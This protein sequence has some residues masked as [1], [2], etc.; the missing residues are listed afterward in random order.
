MRLNLSHKM[1]NPFTSLKYP[2]FRYFWIGMCVSTIGTWMQNVAQPWLAYSLTD[3]P[4]L[5]SLVGTLQFLPVM[6]MSLFAGAFIDR[7]PKK[8]VLLCTQSALLLITMIMTI[9]VLTKRIEYWHIL[10]LATLMGIANTFDMPARQSIVIQLIEKESLMNAIALNSIAFN[11]AR[12]IGPTI[13]GLLMSYAGIGFCFMINSISYGAVLISL[14]FI[15]PQYPETIKPMKD[16]RSIVSE[17]L[18]GLTYIR[19]KPQI[20]RSLILIGI[21]GTFALNN[22]V[23]VPV[24]IKQVL[25]L[26]ETYFGLT[27]SLMGIGSLL[28]SFTTASFSKNGPNQMVLI[29]FPF[30]IGMALFLAGFVNH[31]LLLGGILAIT[32]FFF[33]VFSSTINTSIQIDLDNQ[34]RGRVM[35]VYTLVFAGTTPFGSLFAGSIDNQF[36]GRAGFIAC[37]GMTLLLIAWVSTQMGKKKRLE[38][39]EGS[40]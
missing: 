8:K 16:Q 7:F 15:K 24:F 4:L 10:I 27:I 11:M 21:V 9:L 1:N 32:G 12:V 26:P 19:S 2:N 29:Y 33:I 30:I 13:A 23:L 39:T 25:R 22:N 14:L 35:S 36:G 5:L 34:F 31:F 3:S 38:S 20:L 37:G 6:L 28:G 17:I 40:L 18:E